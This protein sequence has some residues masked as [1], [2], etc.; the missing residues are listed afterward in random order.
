[1]VNCKERNL[2]AVSV[3][4]S[5]GLPLGRRVPRGR[6]R[7]YVARV[8]EGREA[9]TCARLRRIFSAELLE[10]AFE[11]RKER[12]FHRAREGWSLQCVPSYAGY[13]FLVTRDAPAL[14]AELA[15]LSFPVG[16]VGRSDG[17]S[18]APLAEGARMWFE[19]SLDGDRVL[20]NSTAEIVDGALHVLEGPLVGQEGR[21]R[22]IDRHRRVCLVSVFDADGGFVEAMPLDVPAKR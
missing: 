22:K 16:L 6:L 1:M 21:I 5:V 18:W 15:A 13:I 12:W 7:W 20:R 10:D 9:W 14:N 17:R 4:P 2:S 11:V 8:P 3:H 19:H